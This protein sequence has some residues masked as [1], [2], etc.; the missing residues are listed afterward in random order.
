M[1]V[2]APVAEDVAPIRFGRE[3]AGDLEVAEQ[4]EWLVTNGIGGYGSGTVAGTITR[5]YHGLLVASLKPPIDRRLMLV[6]LDETLTYRGEAYDLAADRWASGAVSS[7]FANIESFELEGSIPL[8]RYACAEAVI[9]KRI[10]MKAGAN[11]TFVAYTVVSAAE[12]VRLSIRAIV[13]NR[14]FHNTGMVSWPQSVEPVDG[15]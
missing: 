7:G 1:T 2:A 8:W 5:G 4:R 13:D 3:V 10:W 14:V 15:G 9:E 6:K 12:P 11:T